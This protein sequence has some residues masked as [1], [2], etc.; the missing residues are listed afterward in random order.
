MC[1]PPQEAVHKAP[2]L[3]LI[4]CSKVSDIGMVGTSGGKFPAIRQHLQL[5]IGN[6]YN[7]LGMLAL[8]LVLP[9]NACN[10]DVSA[11]TFPDDSVERDPLACLCPSTCGRSPINASTDK[12]AL[13]SM[14]PGDIV[15][16]FTP[17][18][19]HFD[20]AK[21]A[22]EVCISGLSLRSHRAMPQRK[23]HVL[24]TK[25]AVKTLAEHQELE[26]LVSILMSWCMP[27]MRC[28]Q[29]RTACS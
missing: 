12:A 8:P 7:G 29:P 13:D 2:F 10:T 18:D 25:P 9:L 15:T 14:Q 16:I 23:L 26:R 21:Y 3:C 4:L 20:I 17:D 24:I 5:N 28:R 6:A 1:P 19:T 27:L 22:I 11:R